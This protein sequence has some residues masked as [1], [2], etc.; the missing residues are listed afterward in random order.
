MTLKTF[1]K[2]SGNKSK[3]LNKILPYIPSEY[4]T[5][6]EPF[7]GSGAL[8]LRLE[9]KK[10]LIN[11]LNKDCINIWNNIKENPKDIISEFKN[12]GRIFK[13]LTQYKKRKK[14]VLK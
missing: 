5:Y 2:W 3:H 11:D 14:Y 9:P 10:W 8:F 7:V 6:I 4:N 13:P 12:F 1:I